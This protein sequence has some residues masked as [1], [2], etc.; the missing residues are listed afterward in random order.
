[1]N[2]GHALTYAILTDDTNKII[3]RSEV[4]SG[5][6]GKHINLRANDWGD[7]EDKSSGIIRSPSDNAVKDG[8]TPRQWLLLMLKTF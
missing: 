5:D 4:R 1:M 2:V 3:Y 7:D 8:E 6:D